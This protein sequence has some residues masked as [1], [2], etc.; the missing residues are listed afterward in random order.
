LLAAFLTTQLGPV[1]KPASAR[2]LRAGPSPAGGHSTWRIAERDGIH[3]LYVLFG[4]CGRHIDYDDLLAAAAPL[5]GGTSLASL[6]KLANRFGVR[7]VARR[8][9]PAELTRDRLPAI[10]H[11]DDAAAGSGRFALL[12][13]CDDV[14]CLLVS[15]DEVTI[16]Q[17][18]SDKFRRS[19]TGVILERENGSILRTASL[20]IG[21]GVCAIAF[22]AVVCFQRARRGACLG[23]TAGLQKSI[24]SGARIQS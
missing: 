4:S 19:W 7:L 11:L 1:A 13:R 24:L 22:Y 10:V 17:M 18:S 20:S 9:T 5:G 12:L 6:C 21:Y 3:C 8:R 15:G 16:E 14:N 2:S 23:S